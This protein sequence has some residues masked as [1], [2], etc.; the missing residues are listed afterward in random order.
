MKLGLWR[1]RYFYEW[2]PRD[3]REI[4]LATAFRK[5]RNLLRSWDAPRHMP[6]ATGKGGDDK[7]IVHVLTGEFHAHLTCF[8]LFSLI[9]QANAG[10]A[11]IVHEDRTLKEQ[12]RDQLR[13]LI[14]WVRFVA[15]GEAEDLIETHFPRSRY[16]SLRA[17]RD[18]LPLMRKLMD[19]HAGQKGPTLFID[20]DVLFHRNPE[21]LL[22]WLRGG[23][24]A[25]YL[26]DYQDSYGLSDSDLEWVYGR[27][28]PPRVNTG[29]CGFFSPN[30]DWD[31][32]EHWAALLLERG[33]VN[34]FSEQALT[35]MAMGDTASAA[36]PPE[37][38]IVSPGVAE[39]RE[40]R[41]VMHHYV[42]PSRTWYY[43]DALPKF[44][45]KLKAW[46]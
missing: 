11:P 4:G 9:E 36:A 39:T 8:C 7:L 2:L 43:T 44:L 1:L 41:A 13:R 15:N 33:G 35:A 31:K 12:Q 14:P 34:H 22:Q 40:P 25:L 29:L 30:L 19:V 38:Y 24:G 42:V 46:R 16:R 6:A 17:M 20:S 45:L 5:H 37:D 26:R 3:G 27:P 23:R 32:L 28:L 10:I 21:Y 18:S